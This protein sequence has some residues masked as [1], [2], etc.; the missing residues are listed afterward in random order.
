MEAR[1]RIRAQGRECGPGVSLS[2]ASNVDVQCVTLYAAC[3]VDLQGV[4]PSNFSSEDVQG[5]STGTY[6]ACRV[7]RAGVSL[8]TTSSVDLQGVSFSTACSVDVQGVQYNF[9][10]SNSFFYMPDC[11][12]SGQSGTGKNE[13]MPKLEPVQYRNKGIQSDYRYC[14]GGIYDTTK[15]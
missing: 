8:S 2:T 6:T 5:A 7:K 12:A 13:K 9:S 1:S 11:P 10:P 3:S 14:G 4:S 15:Q